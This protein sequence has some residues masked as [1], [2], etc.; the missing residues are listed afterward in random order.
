MC[1]GAGQGE[2]WQGHAGNVLRGLFWLAAPLWEGFRGRGGV[3]LYCIFLLCP[4]PL[5]PD[6]AH[7][8]P[9]SGEAVTC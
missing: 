5:G 2:V 9:Q 4:V 8:L 1:W 6:P 7:P 3:G